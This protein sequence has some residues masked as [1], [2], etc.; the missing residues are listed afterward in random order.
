MK[1]SMCTVF[2]TGLPFSG[3]D[4]IVTE[5][6]LQAWATYIGRCE[7]VQVEKKVEREFPEGDKGCAI[8]QFLTR[9]GAGKF[10]DAM[11]GKLLVRGAHRLVCCVEAAHHDLV[12]GAGESQERWRTTMP[13]MPPRYKMK[14]DV[15]NG[16]IFAWNTHEARVVA[17]R[18]A[19]DEDGWIQAWDPSARD[20]A[21]V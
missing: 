1:G 16:M 10:A 12:R 15:R 21:W 17:E 19:R 4:L 2:V 3:G 8:I 5:D 7:V 18:K 13:G 14:M 9:E 20:G 6:R 11:H